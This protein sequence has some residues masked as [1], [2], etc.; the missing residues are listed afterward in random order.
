MQA[1]EISRNIGGRVGE[2]AV[3][4]DRAAVYRLRVRCLVPMHCGS[5]SGEAGEVMFH[6]VE[7]KPFI[8]ASGIAGALRDYVFHQ[9][10]ERAKE[11]FGWAGEEDGGMKSRVFVTDGEFAPSSV[12]I[13][14]RPRVKI[15][16]ETG[17]CHVQ[18]VKGREVDSGQKFE[19]EVVSAGAEFSFSLY[20]YQQGKGLEVPL[21][22]ALAALHRGQIWLGGQKSNGCGLVELVSA[23]K[24]VY[25][26]RSPKDRELWLEEEKEGEEI[27]PALCQME[28]PEG[29]YI[30][31]RL[32]GKTQGNILVKASFAPGWG[33]DSPDF[34]NLKNYQGESILPGSS[35]KGVLRSQ[36]EKIGAYLNLEKEVTEEI[37]GTAL[38]DGRE[39][40]PGKARFYDSII[41]GKTENDRAS[42]QYRIHVDKFTGGVMYGSL[43]SEKP[44]YGNVELCIEAEESCRMGIA[45]LLLALRDVGLGILPLGSEGSIGRGYLEGDR[46]TLEKDGDI[47]AEIDFHNGEIRKGRDKLEGYLKALQAE[48]DR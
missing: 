26:L 16:P 12:N 40:R 1:S 34:V 15:N 37:F 3:R 9:D 46:L 44:A 22:Q 23:E 17:S 43:F 7:K 13:E 11:L 36:A 32:T 2:A 45:L 14:C 19:V 41:G 18:R 48:K 6:P 20:L 39:G 35:I 29:S 5:G 10:E 28:E 47:L 38:G 27:L 30:C 4:Y 8:Q 33:K 42:S 24:A 31:F 25:D 21:E